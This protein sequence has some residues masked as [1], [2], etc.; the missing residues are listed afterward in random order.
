MVYLNARD[1]CIW[2]WL[3]WCETPPWAL[4]A[5]KAFS[6]TLRSQNFDVTNNFISLVELYKGNRVVNAGEKL[7]KHFEITGTVRGGE[8]LRIRTERNS[9]LRECERKA[10]QGGAHESGER[11]SAKFH[12]RWRSL[13]TVI[14]RD[15]TLIENYAEQFEFHGIQVSEP[16][17]FPLRSAVACDLPR[18]ILPR[19]DRLCISSLPP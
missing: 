15:E 16:L 8:P 4:S 11:Q 17:R 9:P 12:R 14:P 1:N 5:T 7:A 19:A 2:K 3:H 13:V 18:G 6:K 10:R